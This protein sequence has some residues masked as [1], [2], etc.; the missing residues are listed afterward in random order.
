MNRKNKDRNKENE[1]Q[2]IQSKIQKVKE[3]YVKIKYLTI[4]VIILLPLLY[5]LIIKDFLKFKLKYI[6]IYII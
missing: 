3:I 1:C 5:Y 2:A 6:K 4:Y